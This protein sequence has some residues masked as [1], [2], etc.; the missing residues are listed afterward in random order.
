MSVTVQNV[1]V[2]V[3][4]C[5]HGE[6][7]LFLHGNPD[8]ADIWNDVILRLQEKYR[9]IAI[10]LPGFARTKTPRDFDYSFD[11][12]GR[13]LD[14]FVERLGIDTP[15][16]VVAHDFGGAFA[17]AWAAMHLQKV[18]RIVI[19]NHPF[20]VAEYT[21]HFWGR[22]WRTP[23]IGELSMLL[24]NRPVLSWTMRVASKK[25]SKEQIRHAYS[26]LSESRWMILRLY[27]AADPKEFKKWEPL[28][29]AATA[30]IPTLVLWGQHDP[31][32]PEWVVEKFGAKKVTRFQ[33]SGHWAPAE[34][35]ERIS[36]E[37]MKFLAS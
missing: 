26:I 21:W 36:V 6:P 31:F 35:P 2:F 29:L 32:I 17:M 25:L 4:E 30:K 19:I 9:C 15:L 11:N 18:R 3:R 23:L 33:E 14:T 24:L 7:V 22:V 16:N 27:R 20:F 5:G 1:D 34:V 37:L 12:L 10:D 8:S 28:M 13:F